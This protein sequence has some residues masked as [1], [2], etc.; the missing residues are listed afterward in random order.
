M[1]AIAYATDEKEISYWAG[2]ETF[3]NLPTE[4][5]VFLKEIDAEKTLPILRR[6]MEAGLQAGLHQSAEVVPLPDDEK[7]EEANAGSKT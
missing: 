6:G 1:F 5:V 2:G 4:A 3:S 7:G